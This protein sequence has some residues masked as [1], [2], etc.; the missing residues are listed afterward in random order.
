MH[1]QL[2][3]YIFFLGKSVLPPCNPRQG[4]S[5]LNPHIVSRCVDDLSSFDES[6]TSFTMCTGPYH[7][8]FDAS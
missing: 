5:P 7:C 3:K 1:F 4:A 6:S 8:D 2:T